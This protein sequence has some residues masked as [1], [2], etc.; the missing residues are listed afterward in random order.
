MSD[1]RF[2]VS[3]VVLPRAAVRRA[4]ATLRDDAATWAAL[5]AKYGDLDAL[6]ERLESYARMMEEGTDDE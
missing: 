5:E 3:P 2:L 4:L 6:H 1:R